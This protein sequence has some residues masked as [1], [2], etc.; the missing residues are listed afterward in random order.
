MNQQVEPEPY[1][2]PAL[3]EVGEFR[4]DTLGP[5][6]A[7]LPGPSAGEERREQRGTA[8]PECAR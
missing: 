7:A 5:G 2:P 6:S 3:L 1:E 4:E 8:A